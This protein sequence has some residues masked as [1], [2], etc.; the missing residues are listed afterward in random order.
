M[1]SKQ[2]KAVPLYAMEALRGRGVIAPIHD[3]G[4]R[5]GWVVSITPRPRFTPGERTPGTH[6]RR[7]WVGP[8][9]GLDTEVRGKIIC[10]RRGS[11]PDR[12]VVQ[13]VVRHYTAWAMQIIKIVWH[14]GWSHR[15]QNLSVTLKGA[16][17]AVL[18]SIFRTASVELVMT[19]RKVQQPDGARPVHWG[20][21]SL[22][23]KPVYSEMER[24]LT[25]KGA[26]TRRVWDRVSSTVASLQTF[27]LIHSKTMPSGHTESGHVILRDSCS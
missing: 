23:M 26:V 7:G 2:S 21:M 14:C 15:V 17:F 19:P 20:H 24:V 6:W 11:N 16:C 5:W 22:L 8:R 3:L 27:C 13:P 25:F 12:P 1:Q 10:P 18:T 9:A 4:T